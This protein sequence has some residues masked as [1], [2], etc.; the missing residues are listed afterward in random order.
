MTSKSITQKLLGLG[1]L[2]SLL[3]GCGPAQKLSRDCSGTFDQVCDL[4]LG[5]D[6]DE[7]AEHE[8][9]LDDIER[10][11]RSLNL[12]L[13]SIIETLNV[14]SQTVNVT[15]LQLA[16]LQADADLVVAEVAVLSGYHNIAE[17]VDPCGDGPGYDEVVLKT[18]QDEFLAYFQKGSRRHLAVL[19]D[20]NYETTDE[21]RCEFTIQNGQLTSEVE[22]DN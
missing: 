11:L 3:I 20:G 2:S 18:S 5:D 13:T 17:I 22:N 12:E 9:R 6:S 19:V 1:L 10:R 16:D 4:V 15:Q 14:L 7:I 21:Q 8:D